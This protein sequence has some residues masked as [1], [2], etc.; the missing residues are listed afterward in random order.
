M[1]VFNKVIVCLIMASFIFSSEGFAVKRTP[2]EDRRSLPIKPRLKRAPVKKRASITRPRKAGIRK[3]ST[4]RSEAVRKR[5]S[6]ARRPVEKK[7]PAPAARKKTQKKVTHRP[8]ERKRPIQAAKTTAKKNISKPIE[9]KR[10]AQTVRATAKKVAAT[11][12]V[13]TPIT[14]RAAKTTKVVSPAKTNQQNTALVRNA[15]KAP[16]KGKTNPRPANTRAEKNPVQKKPPVRP[17]SRKVT[18]PQSY[19]MN[20]KL[21]PKDLRKDLRTFGGSKEKDDDDDKITKI[22]PIELRQFL[23]MLQELENHAPGITQRSRQYFATRGYNS[24]KNNDVII[25]L[26]TIP[27]ELKYY[28]DWVEDLDLDDE[29]NP[30]VSSAKVTKWLS[31]MQQHEKAAKNIT[32]RLRHHLKS[33]YGF[34]G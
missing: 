29:P 14:A 17:A 6:I 15:R 30:K 9:K 31:R 11:P 21:I 13:K 10:P 4:Q 5:Q 3:P 18:G 34:Q 20:P 7:R 27:V 26:T 33:Q 32:A 16:V 28:L 19:L 22:T 25:D 23:G 1:R 24:A 12:P 2:H 8:V